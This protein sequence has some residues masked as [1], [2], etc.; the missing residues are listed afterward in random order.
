MNTLDAAYQPHHGKSIFLGG[1][2]SGLGGTV[3]TMR[4]I[5]QY[6]QFFPVN[7]RRNTV[8][9]N[10]QGSFISGYNGVVAP[11]FERAYLGGDND[12]R[13]FD[14][15]TIS[16][17]AFLPSHQAVTLTNPDGTPVPKDPRNPRAGAWT[18]PV[19]F[20]QLV[21]PGG[22][23]SLTGNLE[24][25]ITIAGPVVLAPFVDVGVNP[26]VRTSQLKINNGQFDDLLNTEFGCPKLDPALQCIN[27]QKI[28]FSQFLQPVP[29][30]NWVPRMSTG[31][32]LQVM[33]PVINAP[34]RIYWAYNL[35]RL[36]TTTNPPVPITRDMF[37]C[38]V[39]GDPSCV[40]KAAGDFTYQ[41][42][43]DTLGPSY[44]LRE[45][46][47]TFRFSVSTTF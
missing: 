23:L 14:I 35:L 7:K 29:G 21:T 13:G 41:Q 18:I 26:I 12:L 28:A 1:E 8:G 24:Y 4:P 46:R 44:T 16:P 34:F 40:N 27:G 36:N 25:R 39:A 43:I 15:R 31:I 38:P 5:V 32:E 9:Y 20:E 6:K 45:P 22:D 37:P 33:L 2:F 47:K 11:P 10:L 42:T 3:Y 30:T 17:I 19:P